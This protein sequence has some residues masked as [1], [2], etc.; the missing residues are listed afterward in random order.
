MTFKVWVKTTGDVRWS[1]NHVK[2]ETEDEAR[3]AGRDLFMR[4]FAVE[5]WDVFEHGVN[6]NDNDTST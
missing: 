5:K 1:T 6:P 3:A 2:H 4:W